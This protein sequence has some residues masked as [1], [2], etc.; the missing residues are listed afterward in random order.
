MISDEEYRSVQIA[1]ALRPEQGDLIKGGRGLRK[2]RWAGKQ[3]GKRGG[4]RIIYYWDVKSET[5]YL[6]LIYPKTAQDD[7]TLEQ[8][9]ILSKLVMEGL[10]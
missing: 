3:K 4:F 6:L 8:Q 2:I 1:L 9:K 7:L 5:I 10:E